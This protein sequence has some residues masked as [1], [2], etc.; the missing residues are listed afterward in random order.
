M[1]AG[2]KLL[3]VTSLIV[4]SGCASGPLSHDEARKRIAAIAGSGLVPQAVEIRRI[5]SQT[6]T[7][8]IAESTVSLAV[9]FKRADAKADWQIEAVRLGDRD[10][11]SLNELLA[12]IDETRRQ[13]TTEALDKL[14]A[15]IAKYRQRNGSIPAAKDIVGLTDLLHPLYMTDLVRLDGWGNPIEYLPTGT[16]TFRLFSRG[17]DGRASTRDDIVR[18]NGRTVS[19]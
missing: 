9:Q 19:P 6:D 3:L 4:I 2:L 10:W 12:A 15:G 14:A 11:I 7:Q 16:G 17:P 5:V 13:S 8:V 1:R 18:E